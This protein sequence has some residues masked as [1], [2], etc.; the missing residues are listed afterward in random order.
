MNKVTLTPADD[1]AGC[2]FPFFNEPKKP[3]EKYYK[4]Y[5]DGGHYVA[6]PYFHSYGKR[7]NQPSPLETLFNMLYD[8]AYCKQRR[9]EKAQGKERAPFDIE[10]FI[11]S[12][13]PVLR[14][15]FPQNNV[16]RD[17]IIDMIKRKRERLKPEKKTT[18]TTAIDI[19]FDSLYIHALRS[20][21]KDDELQ[22]YIRT[23]LL[24]VFADYDDLDKFISDKLE[25]K[26]R[27]LYSR[28]K[29]F[30]RKAALNRWNYFVTFTYDDK[31][32][33]EETFRKK[34]RKCLSN[35]HTRRGWKYMGVFECAPETGR[36]HFHGL[37]YIPDGQMIGDVTELKDYSTAQGKIQIT[38]SNSFFAE[39]FGRNDFEK[40]NAMELKRGNTLNYLLKYISKTGERIVYSRGIPTAICKEIDNNDIAGKMI[41]FMAKFVLFDDTID[42]ERDIMHYKY[43]QMTIIDLLCNPPQAA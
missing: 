7:R 43:K 37:L 22:N 10:K 23:C 29:R 17:M 32:H 2:P 19:A 34:L 11:E 3:V 4:I 42:W 1:V 40:L 28:K 18:K 38:H 21:L 26:V 27:N 39:A 5:N 25:R 41:D 8:D 30:R 33:T 24:K 16:T 14:A 6:T 15:R 13:L 20:G 9:R 36:L 12:V 35:L 31:K